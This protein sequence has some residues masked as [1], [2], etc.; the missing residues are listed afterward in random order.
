MGTLHDTV[1]RKALRFALGFP[2]VLAG[3]FAVSAV[4]IR[5][6]LP[7]PLAVAWNA[8]GGAAFAPFEAYVGLGSALIVVLGWMIFLQAVPVSRPTVMRRI[9]MGVG[10]FSV[11]FITSV[12]A[13]GLIGQA[14]I[15]DARDSRVDA[16]V[17]ALGSGAAVGLGVVMGFVFKADQQWSAEDDSAFKRELAHL[18]DP[19]L[20]RDSFYGWAHAR[21][22][23]FVMITLAGTS[24]AALLFLA[25]PWLG[26][27]LLALAV[28][29]A[30]FLVTRISADRLGLRVYLAGLIPVVRL[31]AA[32]IDSAQ[33]ADVQ[34]SD[35]GGW[36]FRR[37]GATTA[38]LVRSGA[39]VVVRTADGRKYVLSS[40]T[41][42]SAHHLAELLV[43]VSTR[44]RR[45]P[46][47]G[48]EPGPVQPT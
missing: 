44:A 3:A 11:L 5:P 18:L 34:A 41:A 33:A 37:E 20:A 2:V 4:L 45:P 46:S 23:I 13:A 6:D 16:T 24:P 42:D 40:P 14:G 26:L 12:L 7:A 47:T 9:M 8:E 27:T 43:R 30:A 38:V 21:S 35:Y 10:L 32:E 17:L 36:G 28:V 22:S 1:D 15:A 19:D 39:A 29:A 25:V 31:R 48:G